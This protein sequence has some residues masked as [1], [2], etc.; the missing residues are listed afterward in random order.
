MGGGDVLLCFWCHYL[1]F[2]VAGESSD[3]AYPRN[4]RHSPSSR[5]VCSALLCS[6]TLLCFLFDAAQ[7]SLDFLW[8][9]KFLSFPRSHLVGHIWSFSATTLGHS[10]IAIGWPFSSIYVY[11]GVGPLP[12]P[13][14]NHEFLLPHSRAISIPS[15]LC[16]C[17]KSRVV[18]QVA[19]CIC[20]K[21]QVVV[22]AISIPSYL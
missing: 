20:G 12:P 14:E 21:S 3:Y 5:F 6:T 9:H 18:V 19:I 1:W 13:K 10:F 8:A 16:K 7:S 4:G 22:R 15:Y 11:R 2:V 17:G